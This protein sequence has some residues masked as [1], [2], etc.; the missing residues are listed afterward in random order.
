MQWGR[1]ECTSPPSSPR[2]T[3]RP[4]DHA[5]RGSPAWIQR[6][7]GG[8]GGTHPR[9][10]VH[11]NEA[12]RSAAAP[13]SAVRLGWCQA[14]VV[15]LV[16]GCGRQ[17]AV[18]G[19]GRQAAVV[20][21]RSSGWWGG[22]Q[23]WSSTTER[24]ADGASPSSCRLSSVGSSS[25]PPGGASSGR[26]RGGCSAHEERGARSSLPR[27]QSKT[28]ETGAEGRKR[29]TRDRPDGR[30]TCRYMAVTWPLHGRYMAVTGGEEAAHE[31]SAGREAHL[32][33]VTAVCNGR[34]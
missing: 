22:R 26:P 33:R 2:H 17:A 27:S 14:A 1:G 10:I 18:V 21:L 24:R 12:R 23:A 8:G 15:R 5:A 11:D 31:G 25:G 3:P 32:P 16:S 9:H 6:E 30:R 4:I 7:G 34:A 29:R 20:R 19:R 28:D 13:A